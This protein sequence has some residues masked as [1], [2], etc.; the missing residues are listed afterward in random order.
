[1]NYVAISVSSMLK[2]KGS[3]LLMIAQLVFSFWVINHAF[4]SMDVVDYQEEKLFATAEIDK[5]TT[6]RLVVSDGEDTEWFADRFALL[7][8]Y[9]KTIPGVTGYGSFDTTSIRPGHL[10]N[11]QAYLEQNQRDYA[12]TRRE[13][14]LDTSQ[15]VFLD[16]DIYKYAKWKVIKGRALHKED[17]HKRNEDVIPVLVGYHYRNVMNIGDRF[18]MN[19]HDQKIVYEVAGVL[20]Q[21]SE[22]L[23]GND[24]ITDPVDN[25]D[26][27]IIAPF[28]PL[29]RQSEP[30]D[31]A[32]R[33]HN[34]F[35]QLDSTN[36]YHSV[37]TAIK[38]K[39]R[40]LGINPKLITVEEELQ[41]YK[42]SRK[43]TS[44]FTL[45]LGMF[46]LVISII[47][48]ISVTL[49]SIHARKHE[50]GVRMVTGAS[51]RDISLLILFEL[52]LIVFL[53]AVLGVTLNYLSERS[54]D[55]SVHHVRLAIFA[56]PLYLKIAVVSAVV[57]LCSVFI[58]LLKIRKLQLSALVGGRD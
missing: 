43:Q 2:R 16:H 11:Q 58:P 20:A 17:F 41:A 52:G 45:F 54:G 8:D 25:L 26:N 22:W 5:K 33:L 50:L 18:E 10:P 49:S 51:K 14:E 7:E 19:I 30:M 53:S 56:W 21:G 9:I 12:G 36:D 40:E 44:D 47:G 6:L 13:N 24:Y 57:I 29:I 39:G 4:I 42:D 15:A 48:V 35:V 31:V 1:M 27:F 3:V 34:T 37:A 28:C 23:S 38:K 32:V 46:F 55:P